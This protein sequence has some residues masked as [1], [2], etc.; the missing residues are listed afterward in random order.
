[1]KSKHEIE[2]KRHIQFQRGHTLGY[3]E[4]RY[5]MDNTFPI[6]RYNGAQNKRDDCC[7]NQKGVAEGKVLSRP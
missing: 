4:F 5:Q 6:Q 1:M 7:L 2:P 3:L